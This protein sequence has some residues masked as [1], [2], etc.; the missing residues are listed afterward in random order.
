MPYV[1]RVRTALIEQLKNGVR[2]LRAASDT[3]LSN[4]AYMVTHL[5]LEVLTHLLL[6]G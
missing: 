3:L 6:E 1:T 2:A 5:L 4:G